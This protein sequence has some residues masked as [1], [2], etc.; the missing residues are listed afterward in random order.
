MIRSTFLGIEIGRRGI[1][2]ARFGLDTTGHNISNANT[3]GYSRQRVNLRSSFPLAFPGPFVTLRPGQIGTGV[4]VRSV[5]RIRSDFVEA[6]IHRETGDNN[7][8]LQRSEIFAHIENIL[9]E[10]SDNA[11]NGLMQGFFDAWEDLSNDPESLA[12]RTQVREAALQLTDW[13]NGLD[14]SF[15]QELSDIN[16]QIRGKVSQLNGMT[17]EVAEINRQIIASEAD[18]SID[19][20]KANDLKD[21]RDALIEQISS[22]VNARVLFTADG[23]VSVLVQGHPIVQNGTASEL[24]VVPNPDDPFRPVIEFKDSRIP[25]AITSGELHGLQ[26]MRDTEIPAVQKDI[27]KLVTAF[28]NRVN[29][30]HM[31]G[32]GLDGNKGRPFFA[33]REVRR[34]EGNTVL[35]STTDLNTTLDKLGISAGDFFVQGQ[36]I[37]IKTTEVLPG[38][39]ITLGELVKRIEDA[40]IDVRLNLDSSLGFTRLNLGQFNPVERDTPLTIANGNSNFLTVM[41]LDTAP[42]KQV[43]LEP[44]YENS[45]FNFK[46]NP[47]LSQ[48]LD[49]LAAAGDDGLGFPGPGDN[50]TALALADLKNS[51]KAIEGTTFGEYYQSAIGRLGSKAQAAESA[52]QTSTLALEQLDSKRQEISGVNLDEEAVNLIKYQKAFEASSRV[53]NA[54]D[55]IL[56]TIIQR[57]GI[58]G[59]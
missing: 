18:G 10:P 15:K 21:R 47:A 45:L 56:E 46:L 54:M 34:F 49:A 48:N 27:A 40:T 22:I 11:L 23:G 9:G 3:P 32:Y 1:L 25:L 42:L 26:Q 41:G 4:E 59:R 35:P 50:R 5:E 7:L 28:T 58:V 16:E 24:A 12:T 53:I 8:F 57:M 13:V 43:D 6:Q 51:V 2:A 33:D 17:A 31:A 20:M 29:R 52:Y 38:T 36:R 37:E 14:A 39:A 55:E 44:A 30:L 19:S